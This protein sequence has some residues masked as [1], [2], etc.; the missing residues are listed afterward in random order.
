MFGTQKIFGSLGWSILSK[1]TRQ[2][3]QL[4]IIFI[5]SRIL[6]PA[7]FGLM[8]MV[9]AFS[10]L[11]EIVRNMGMGAAVIQ[12]PEEDPVLMDTAFTFNLFIGLCVFA[13][14]YVGA[15]AISAFYGQ[16]ALTSLIR[17]FASVYIIGSFNIVQEALLQKRMQFRRLFMMDLASVVVS[18]VVAIIM[19]TRGWGVWSLVVQYIVMIAISSVVLWVTSTWKPKLRF[20]RTVF[21]SIRK[22]SF[23][24]FV[25]DLIYFLGR[26]TDKFL[27]GKYLGP[28]VL[29]LYYRAFLLTLLP[30]NQIN[31]VVTRVMFPVFSAMQDDIPAMRRTYLKATNMISYVSFPVLALLFQIAEPLVTLLL[32]PAWSQSALYL[33]MFCLYGMLESV[34]TTIYWIY[35]SLGR[36]DLMLRWG[37]ISTGCIIPAFVIGIWWKGATGIAVCY[38][39]VQLILW[40]PGWRMAFQL[41]G[42]RLGDMIRNIGGNFLNAVFSILPAILLQQ[43]IRSAHAITVVASTAI[44]Y[45]FTY[46]V[47]SKLTRQAGFT[48]IIG[49]LRRKGFNGQ[50][51]AS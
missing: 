40:L 18:G 41:I 8:S 46:L 17:V 42:L 4:I 49:L 12:R 2:L 1:I 25:H 6:S 29:G 15:P 38:V 13:G 24:L 27:I 3:L 20:D 9:T 30:V 34:G 50:P 21:K 37:L 7:E 35:K 33:R 31:L 44:L 11:A 45:C 36:T 32:G 39:A 43:S 10:M 16:P 26:D 14:F 19:A 51:K 23:Q 28:V 48:F 5:L 47:M 22:F